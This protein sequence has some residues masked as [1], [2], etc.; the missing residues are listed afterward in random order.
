M[1]GRGGG[2]KGG[3]R[4]GPGLWLWRHGTVCLY[5][6]VTQNCVNIINN[7]SLSTKTLKIKY[8]S[9]SSPDC[10]ESTTQCE[11]KRLLGTHVLCLSQLFSTSPKAVPS[12]F[13]RRGVEAGFEYSEVKGANESL[14]T[15]IGHYCAGSPN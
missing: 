10:P 2:W 12:H 9:A 11:D 7:R 15:E 5:H 14:T 8:R 4:D 3:G 13:P 6:A 1:E